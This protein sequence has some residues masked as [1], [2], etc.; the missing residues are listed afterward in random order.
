LSHSS[1]DI[2]NL[3]IKQT[4]LI[5]LPGLSSIQNNASTPELATA[6]PGNLSYTIEI[7]SIK[8]SVFENTLLH[9]L[10]ARIM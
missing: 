1:N 6:K 10:H 2:L 8:G 5:P 4:G 9:E 3:S 7:V